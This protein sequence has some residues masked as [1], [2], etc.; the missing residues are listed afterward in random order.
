M[1]AL[2]AEVAVATAVRCFDEVFG[3]PIVTQIRPAEKFYV[4]EDYHQEYFRN[5][6]KQPYCAYVVAPKLTKFREKFA[7]R[8]RQ[9]G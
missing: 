9:G 3:R 2:P 4:A 7:A 5:N 8:M 1:K 6:P